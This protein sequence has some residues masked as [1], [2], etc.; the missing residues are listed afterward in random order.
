[1]VCSCQSHRISDRSKRLVFFVQQRLRTSQEIFGRGIAVLFTTVISKSIWDKARS[2]VVA[3]RHQATRQVSPKLLRHEQ[4][5][6]LFLVQSQHFD[7]SLFPEFL[8]T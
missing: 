5:G 1:M 4:Q 2:I 8:A 3:V 6:S 7:L